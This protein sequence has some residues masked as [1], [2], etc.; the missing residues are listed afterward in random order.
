MKTALESSARKNSS[1]YLFYQME[2]YK[3]LI[4]RSR[5]FL[6]AFISEKEALEHAIRNAVMDGKMRIF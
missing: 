4:K 2:H 1:R 5:A 3:W 6:T